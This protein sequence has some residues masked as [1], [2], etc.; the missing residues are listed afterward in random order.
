[1]EW[2]EGLGSGFKIKGQGDWVWSVMEWSVTEQGD[3]VEVL[4][5]V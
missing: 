4:V 5:S 3:K 2:K 1:M